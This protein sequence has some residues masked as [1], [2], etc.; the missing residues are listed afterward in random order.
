MKSPGSKLGQ[1]GKR[2][3]FVSKTG[4]GRDKSGISD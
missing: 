4:F 1:E 2:D 3:K